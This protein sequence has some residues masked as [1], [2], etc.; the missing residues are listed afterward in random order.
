[1]ICKLCEED[2]HNFSSCDSYG[3][4]PSNIYW[5][6]ICKLCEPFSHSSKRS[7]IKTYYGEIEII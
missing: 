6:N 2:F 1:M 3:N 5:K 7:E 4:K